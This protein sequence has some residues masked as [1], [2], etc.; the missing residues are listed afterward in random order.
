MSGRTAAVEAQAKV[1][2]FLRILAREQSGYH[3]LET[4][5]CRLDLADSVRVTT[6]RGRR[7]LDAA[8]AES[9]GMGPVERNLAWRA[10]VAY[11][12]AAGWP[13]GFGIE[14]EKR[15]PVGAGLGGGS[16]DA[17]GILRCLNAIA[18]SPLP[19]GVLMG[20][21]ARLGA[22]VPFLTQNRS[23]MALAW[24]RGER[25]LTLPPPPRR[26]C[27]VMMPGFRVATAEA[28]SWLATSDVAT[29]PAELRDLADLGSWERLRESASNSFE[30]V[31]VRRHPELGGQLAKLR[32]MPQFGPVVM[33][34]SGAAVACFSA[35]DVEAPGAPGWSV[36]QTATAR[37]VAAVQVW[38]EG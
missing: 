23:T 16:A 22:D 27:F 14:L 13:Q 26:R 37:A 11:S 2:L 30:D 24:G 3:Q 20:L 31:V 6:G 32:N 4:L 1:N 5:F 33:S 17:G 36:L 15:I 18:P 8:G 34:G 25:M 28:Y 35:G 21:A 9:G 12:E 29:G 19:H 10:A 7:T 38:G